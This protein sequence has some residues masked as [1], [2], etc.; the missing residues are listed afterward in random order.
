MTT[1]FSTTL[2]LA[3][4]LTVLAPQVRGADAALPSPDEAIQRLTEGNTR[5][6]AGKPQHPHQDAERRADAVKGQNPFVSVLSCADSRV[7]VEVLF[8]QGIGDTF[9]V[10]VAGNVV[11]TDEIGTLEYGVGHLNTP[12]LVILGHTSCGAVKAVVEGAQVHG[13]IPAL[14]DNIA[15]AVAQARAAHPDA[16]GPALINA[17]VQANVWVAADDLFKRSAEV[18]QLVAAGKLKVVGAIYHL[19]SGEVKWLG[20]HPEQ[21]RLLAYTGGADHEAAPSHGGAPAHNAVAS[22]EP[23]SAAGEHATGAAETHETGHTTA[24]ATA[25]TSEKLEPRIWRWILGTLAAF[26]VLALAVWSFARSGMNRW[27]VPRRMA[28]GFA[29]VLLVLGVVGFAGYAG[30]HS[31]RTEF[32]EYRTDARL[33]VLAGRIQANFLEMRIAVKDYQVSRD[34]AD[35]SQY[36]ERR[37]K[38]LGFIDEARQQITEPSRKQMVETIVAQVGEHYSLFQQMTKAASADAIAGIGA[39][40]GSVGTTVDHEV[41]QLKLEFVADQN[42]WGPIATRDMQESQVAICSIAVGALLLG[43][44]LTRLISQSIVMPLRGLA[45]TLQAGAEQTTGA[46]GQVSASS[47]SLAEGASEQAASLEETS[48]SLEE[49][50]SMTQRNAQNVKSAKDFT[51]QTRATAESGA[52][53]TQEMGQAMQGIRAASNEMRDAMNGI[54]TASGDVSKII[55]TIDEIAFQTNLLALNAAVE[56]ARAGEAGAGFAVVADEVR[57]LAQRSAT[58]ARETTDLIETSVKRSEDGVRV[59]DK[60]IT[61][62]EEVAVKSQQ[63]EQKLAE[64]VAKAKQVDEQV[65]EIATASQEQSHGIAEVNTAITQMDKV[66]QATASNAEEGAAAA[67]E[68]TAQAESLKAAVAELQQLVGGAT[69][70]AHVA[71]PATP[72]QSPRSVATAKSPRL[73]AGNVDR[74]AAAIPM[75]SPARDQDLAAQFTDC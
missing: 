24:T 46:A 62:V 18:R 29:T 17:A 30:L 20:P 13:S 68:L 11:D 26:V 27:Q 33:S 44:F 50:S 5:Y 35:V 40:M 39:R 1:R 32:A 38:L 45:G 43:M 3:L 41:E 74:Q 16:T 15:P 59:T 48:A 67:E 2:A 21:P 64:I 61:S 70:A 53:S 22:V 34:A 65:T 72:R 75:P 54:K 12:L 69:A 57:S 47:Q 60:V 51:A 4:V 7:P 14:V 73:M 6:A 10:R 58:A 63:L 66:T 71:K 36:E 19:D 9:V 42:H 37:A 28:V 8:D 55:K 31:A 23:H 52:Q 49:I 56:A 25:T